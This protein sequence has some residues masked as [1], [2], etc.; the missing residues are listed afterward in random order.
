MS[1]KEEIIELKIR[2]N[3]LRLKYNEIIGKLNAS[4]GDNIRLRKENEELVGKNK[5]LTRDLERLGFSY[6][7]ALSL[8]ATA[9][10]FVDQNELIHLRNTRLTFQRDQLRRQ[11][12]EKDYIISQLE[13]ALEAAKVI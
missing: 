4:E 10:T 9:T 3:D 13:A 11:L 12:N 6:C 2:N 1:K 5:K 7:A 8:G